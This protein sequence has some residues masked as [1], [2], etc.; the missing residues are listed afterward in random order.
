[1]S[2]I[3]YQHEQI[4]VWHYPQ[5]Q[6]VHHQVHR[7]LRGTPLRE[8]LQRGLDCL[9]DRG[10]IRWL[11]DDRLHYVPPPEDQQW[12]DDVWFPAARDA[13]WKC[14]AIVKPERA[15][16]DLFIRR[17]AAAC[18][19]RGIVT[20]LFSDPDRAMDWLRSAP[21]SLSSA[22]ASSAPSA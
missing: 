19:A 6:M 9:R 22:L 13:G 11:S 5:W 18:S 21:A 3:I 8:A 12:A 14:W 16:A 17:I 20:E 2:E 15:V 1:M 10:A 4:T 7:A